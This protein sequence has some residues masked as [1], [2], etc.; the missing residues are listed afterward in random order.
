[1]SKFKKYVFYGSMFALPWIYFFTIRRKLVQYE[2]SLFN[3]LTDISDEELI[4][5]KKKSSPGN[6]DN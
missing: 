3:K 5:M 2:N 4:K 1:M 6:K